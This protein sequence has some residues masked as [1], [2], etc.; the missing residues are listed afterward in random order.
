[1][2]VFGFAEIITGFTHT[3][4]GLHT[5]KGAVSTYLAAGIGALYAA[6][7]VVVVTMKRR[8][9][10]VAFVLLVIVIAGRLFMTA[11]GLYPLNTLKQT[12]AMI[13][14]TAIALG[15]AI[16]IILNRSAFR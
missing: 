12:A 4:A 6:S 13:A 16:F 9:A 5:A 3:F 2:I 1:M 7:G 15:F 11:M 8:A 14:G 10:M